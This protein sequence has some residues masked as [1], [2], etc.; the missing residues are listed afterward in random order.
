MSNIAINVENISKR[1]RIGKMEDLHDTFMGA[2][3]S[4]V[5]SPVSNFRRLQ[6]LS[7]FAQNGENEDTIWALKNVSFE[8]KH[9]EVLGIIGANG[10]GKSTL[11][12]VLAKISEPT[13]GRIEINGRVASL[14]EVGTGF[15][16][17][18]TG[19]E[20]VYLNGS[21]LGMTKLE[22][23]KNFDEIIDFSGIEKFVDTP[24]KRYSS[25]M[26]VRLAFSVAAF[27]DQEVLLID[28]VLAVGDIDFQKKCIGKIGEVSEQGR[29]VLFVSHN[30][31]AVSSLCS[32][33]CLIDR[34]NLV[35][36]G[37]TKECISQ[38]IGINKK[39][40][41]QKLGK[42]TDRHG[43]QK[44]KFVDIRIKDSN[45]NTTNTV[46]SGDDLI[47]ETDL[48]LKDN[49]VRKVYFQINIIDNLG[50]ILLVCS[51]AVINKNYNEI[52]SNGKMICTIPNLP[53]APGNYSVFLTVKEMR[54]VKMDWIENAIKFNVIEG[55]YFGTGRLI[56]SNT[57][58]FLTKFDIQYISKI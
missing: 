19:R 30:M 48:L 3:I 20:N 45:G 1:Y 16:P 15:H 10:A 49:E 35:L 12:K 43:N 18:L 27:L 40:D 37:E 54:T 47:I 50:R 14:L 51:T 13:S 56:P 55:D 24:V 26:R 11:L 34:G 23:D 39:L 31:A 58:P 33:A 21:I 22:I 6:K 29:T 36:V 57:A 38:Y 4:W 52:K 28:E 41:R 53:L 25:G 32:R 46:A 8:V 2:F 9:G 17:D 44:L 5:K 7:K 42:R